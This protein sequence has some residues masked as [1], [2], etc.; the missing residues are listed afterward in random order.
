MATNQASSLRQCYDSIERNLRSLE[1]IGEDVN[2]QHFIALIS[3]KLPQRVLYQLY[4]LKAEDEEWTVSK[5]RHLLGKHISGMEMAN[6]EFSQAPTQSKHH[7]SLGQNDHPRR[8]HFNS[9][10]T[11]SG[12][13]AGST[14]QCLLRQGVFFVAG[15]IGQMNVPAVNITRKTRKVEGNV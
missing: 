14:K 8:N 4:M 10:P 3:E 7:S 5:L 15:H 1:A 13:L 12:L 11:A 6:L 9:K 2:H